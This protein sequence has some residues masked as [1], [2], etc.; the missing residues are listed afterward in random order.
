MAGRGAGAGPLTF[1]LLQLAESA[2]GAALALVLLLCAPPFLCMLDRARFRA[3][4]T[5]HH[6][7]QGI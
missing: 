3:I 2:N 4:E 6:P 5:I 1:T 7:L